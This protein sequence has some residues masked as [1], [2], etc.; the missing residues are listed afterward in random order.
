MSCMT[1]EHIFSEIRVFQV[2]MRAIG[3]AHLILWCS[4]TMIAKSVIA[5]DHSFL[6]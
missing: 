1:K 4:L 3:M 2:Q 6:P 5:A